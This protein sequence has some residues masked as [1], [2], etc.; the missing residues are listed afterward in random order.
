M[1]QTIEAVYEDGVFKP[2]QPVALDEGQR[3][4]VCISQPPETQTA[5]EMTLEQK[6]RQLGY[7]AFAD[8]PDEEWEKIA[9]GWKRG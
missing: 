4:H 6:M 3:V 9:E 7:Q 2:L 5:A 1:A 8:V